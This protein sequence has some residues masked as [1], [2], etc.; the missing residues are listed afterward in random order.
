MI[1]TPKRQE[2]GEVWFWSLLCA[3]WVLGGLALV[4]AT[5]FAGGQPHTYLLEWPFVAIRDL[6]AQR[7]HPLPWRW[8]GAPTMPSPRLFWS[9]MVVMTGAA[10]AVAVVAVETLRGG[11]PAVFP[12]LSQPAPRSRWGNARSLLAAGLVVTAGGGR[13]RLLLGRHGRHWI[14]AP[15]GVSVVAL[16]P[17]GSGKS[18]GLC[19]PAVEDWEGPVVVVSRRADLVEAAAGVRQHRG[20]VDVLDADSRTGLGTCG[21]SPVDPHLGFD[22][23]VAL[24]AGLVREEGPGAE[25]V[26]QVLTCALYCAANL[27][28]GADTALAWLEDLSGSALV[29]ALLQVPDRDPRAVSWMARVVER[30]GQQRAACFSAARGLLRTHFERVAGGQGPPAFRPVE[31]LA[32]AASTLFVVAPEDP[33]SG[34]DLLGSLL[35]A[36]LMEAGRQ[37]LRRPLLLVL[38]GVG[39][40]VLETLAERLAARRREVTLLVTCREPAELGPGAGAVVEGARVALFLGG[41]GDPATLDLLHR[42][43]VR[44][45]LRRRGPWG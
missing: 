22:D 6:V 37:A 16:G 26:R 18:A 11:I 20:R 25:A 39:A 35:G 33:A 38:D 30:S 19:I 5:A 31:F 8:V 41:G 1:Q 27:A 28:R 32:A 45:L 14:A 2:Q 4:A 15:E 10:A 40:P 42:L 17:A 36:V 13:R 43:V 24:V 44:Q 7:G 34:S 3:L 12:L 23:A 29:H 21:W 9:A